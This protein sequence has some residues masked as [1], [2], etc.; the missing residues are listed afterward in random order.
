MQALWMLIASFFFALMAVCVKVA[1]QWY[2]SGELV[3][4]RGLLGMAFMWLLARQRGMT[5]RTPLV[6]L[7]A[8]R[9]VSGVVSLWAWFYSIAGLPLATAMTLNYMSSV[10]VAAFLL[11]SAL[12]AI[13][14]GQPVFRQGPLALAVLAGFAGVVLML[15]PTIDQ[16]QL[17]AGLVGLFSG[18][19]AAIAYLQ[20]MALGRLGEPEERT[21]FYFSAGSAL[22]GLVVLPFAGMAP[23]DWTQVPWLLA[24][25]ATASAGQWCMTRAYSQGATLVVASLQYSGLVFGAFFGVLLFDETIAGIAW[26][27]MA[28]ILA[29]GIA[30]TALSSRA[31]PDAAADD[32]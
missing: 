30:A 28:L 25:G 26:I 5:L 29:S 12:I 4:W 31:A 13:R 2:G 6:S 18:V 17:F 24:M 15:R 16:D 14:P 22:A 20:V 11:G 7:H 23:W 19:L 27:G 32:H 8:W 3:F 9:S 1:S 21:V 10:W